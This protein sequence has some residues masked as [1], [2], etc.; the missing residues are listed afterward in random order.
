[1]D[2]LATI[3][4]EVLGR[5]A[6]HARTH[7]RPMVEIVVE[8]GWFDEFFGFGFGR[9][10]SRLIMK[11]RMMSDFDPKYSSIFATRG[12][13][14]FPSSFFWSLWI[15]RCDH[16]R[17]LLNPDRDSHHHTPSHD[18]WLDDAW[19]LTRSHHSWYGLPS[20]FAQV[21]VCLAFGRLLWHGHGYDYCLRIGGRNLVH[22]RHHPFDLD[23]AISMAT[24]FVY[25]TCPIRHGLAATPWS[26]STQILIPRIDSI[27][28]P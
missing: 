3:S 5:S 24:V 23:M 16:L 15:Q 19:W 20:S 9:S 4:G 28:F 26:Q 12:K 8:S 13:H 27:C 7:L 22:T 6:Q 25:Q 10:W 2:D 17:F 1:M 21:S 11:W 18:W 14:K